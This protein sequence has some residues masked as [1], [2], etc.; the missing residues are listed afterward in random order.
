M[1]TNIL[2]KIAH[3][4]TSSKIKHVLHCLVVIRGSPT[5]FS[6][7]WQDQFRQDLAGP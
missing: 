4:N 1:S 3:I 7:S 6:G 5:I 2:F